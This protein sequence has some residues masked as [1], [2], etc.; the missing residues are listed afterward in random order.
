VKRPRAAALLGLLAATLWFPA[1]EKATHRK[2]TV[3]FEEL[4][5]RGS[6][7]G[8]RAEEL[9]AFVRRYPRPKTNPFLRRALLLLAEHERRSG[10]AE[11]AASWFEAAVSAFPDDPDLLNA[12]GYHYALNGIRLDRAVAVLETA[13]RLAEERGDGPRRIAFIRD[14]LGWACRARGDLD[15]AVRELEEADRLAPGV[16]VIQEHLADVHRALG[17]GAAR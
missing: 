16:P 15:R 4:M 13:L 17:Q 8:Q 6:L 10:R 14:S 7:P 5:A 9:R 1:C 12:L 2:A 3:A 11:E